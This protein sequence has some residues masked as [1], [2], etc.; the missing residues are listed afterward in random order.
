MTKNSNNSLTCK[1]SKRKINTF[2][3]LLMVN[4]SYGSNKI[5]RHY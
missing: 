2:H 1:I 4:N 5:L 3:Y